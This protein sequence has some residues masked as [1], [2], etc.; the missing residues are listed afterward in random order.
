MSN[1][2]KEP[3]AFSNFARQQLENSKW[4][5]DLRIDTE[6]QKGISQGLP[7][8]G[9]QQMTGCPKHLK[10]RYQ[11]LSEQAARAEEA[12]HDA[13]LEGFQTENGS[14]IPRDLYKR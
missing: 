12:R 3:D 6:L 4:E 13:F 9:Y 5:R 2:V 8:E 11:E 10:G 1:L 14:Y 7:F